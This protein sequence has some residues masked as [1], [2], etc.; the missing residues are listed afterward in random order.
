MANIN[1]VVGGL[2][3]AQV[4]AALAEVTPK[5]EFNAEWANSTGYFDGAVDEVFDGDGLYHFVDDHD[6]IGLIIPTAVGNLILF[7]RYRA[8]KEGIVTYNSSNALR[9]IT[10]MVIEN[11]SVSIADISRLVVDWFGSQDTWSVNF[12]HNKLA[13][14]V[15][16]ITKRLTLKQKAAEAKAE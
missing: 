1:V 12:T 10:G 8:G 9:G 16:Q 5:V 11:N 6:R 3:A 4:I 2:D 7:Q 14:A 13:Q 15:D